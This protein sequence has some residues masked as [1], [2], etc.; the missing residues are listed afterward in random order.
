MMIYEVKDVFPG[1]FVICRDGNNY[2]SDRMAIYNLFTINP[3]Q[4]IPIKIYTSVV[5]I[6][7][8]HLQS[9]F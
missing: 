4:Y 5:R 6:Y 1:R 2:K 8:N 7:Y 9:T 3:P